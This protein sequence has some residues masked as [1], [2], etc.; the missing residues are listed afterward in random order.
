MLALA[1]SMMLLREGSMLLSRRAAVLGITTTALV[2]PKDIRAQLR[3]TPSRDIGPFYPVGHRGDADSDLTL[4]NGRKGRAAGQIIEVIGQVL[5][6]RGNPVQGAVIEL[7]QANA[8]GRYAHPADNNPTAL[9][10]NFQGFAKLKTDRAGGYR[11]TTVKPGAYP[12]GD[13]SP[14]PPHIHLDITGRADRLVTQMLFPGEPLNETDDVVP[15]WARD[16]LIAKVLG[17]GVN[18]TPRYGWDVVLD[19]G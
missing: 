15:Q 8:A 2:L 1:G 4:L 10:P 17:Q 6:K 13:N 18:G 19:R 12:D 14:R 3:T 11:Y 16:R 7:W 5:N 9:D